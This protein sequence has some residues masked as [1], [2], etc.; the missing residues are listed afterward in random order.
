MAKPKV[1]TYKVH[2]LKGE[3]PIGSFT[4]RSDE[5]EELEED[6]NA[7]NGGYGDVR[8]II[9]RLRSGRLDWGPLGCRPEGPEIID[10]TTPF[11]IG[12]MMGLTLEQSIVSDI[13]EELQYR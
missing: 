5:L 6:L 10:I 8:W 11:C 13:C 1:K 9:Y 12:P 3:K 2:D 4:L 7:R